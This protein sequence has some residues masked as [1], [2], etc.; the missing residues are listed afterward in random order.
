MGRGTKRLRLTELMTNLMDSGAFNAP[1]V[2]DR[3]ITG[4]TSNSRDV[5]DGFLFAAL[6]GGQRDGRDYIGDAV[7]RGAAVVLAPDGTALPE[8]TDPARVF[9]VTAGNP[10]QRLARLAARYY[11]GQ[12][13]ITVAITG[14]NGKTSTAEFARQIW[15]RLDKTA[16]SIGTLGLMADGFAAGPSLTTPEPVDLHRMLSTLARSGV[17]RLAIEASSHGL[18]QHRLDGVQF[19]AAAFTSFG[20]D[21]LDYHGDTAHY[22]AAKLRLFSQLLPADGGAVLNADMAAYKEIAAACEDAHLDVRSYGA[23]GRDLR[24]DDLTPVID[25]QRMCFTLAGRSYDTRLPLIGAF[26]ASNALAAMLLVVTCGGDADA[27]AAALP[28]L[29][30]VRGRL[31]L[32]GRRAN[33]AAVY[34]DFAHTADALETVLTTVRPHVSG[35][36][37]VVFGA[38]GD[39]DRGKR[40]LMGQAAARLADTVV[41]TDDN[42]R[43]E[44]A[45]AIR[46]AVMAGCPE[47]REIGDRRAAIN[48]AVAALAGGDILVIAGKGHEPGQIVGDEV[49]P[50]DDVSEARAAIAAADGSDGLEGE[51]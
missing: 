18:D 50:F 26:Q 7:A 1:G 28:R 13:E 24:V 12:P 6:Q 31:E 43:G 51:A 47:G 41:V 29:Q 20:R 11:A 33:G 46:R 23:H 34:V 44:D 39:R 14:T 21:H 16:A 10:R 25:G 4:L 48:S 3:E 19:D 5:K 30:G 37:S 8:G 40:P 27:A 38:G 45:S 42:P 2:R 9:L 35:K 17:S 36:L 15:T 32:A 22:L 49:L